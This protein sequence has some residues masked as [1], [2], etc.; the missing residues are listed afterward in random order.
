[1]S[2]GTPKE[3]L[4]KEFIAQQIKPVGEMPDEPLGA[5]PLAVR[6]GKSVY[7]AVTA[8]PRAERITWLRKTIADAAQR[9]LMGGEK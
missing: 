3:L 4:P 9:E 2:R 1:M 8:L 5:K 6:V 7:D